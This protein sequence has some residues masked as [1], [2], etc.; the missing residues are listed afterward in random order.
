MQ[1]SQLGLSI[2]GAIGPL[3]VKSFLPDLN[4]LEQNCSSADGNFTNS[5]HYWSILEGTHNVTS[6]PCPDEM[7]VT[8]L[9]ASARFAYVTSS[10]LVVIPTA[11]FV[12]VFFL[13]A[14]SCLSPKAK[15]MDGTNQDAGEVK[16][17]Q[18]KIALL[19]GGFVLF[20]LDQP[21]EGSFSNFS[22]VFVVKG[23][24]WPNS[25]GSLIAFVYWAALSFGQLAG[26]PAAAFLS[27]ESM[28]LGLLSVTFAGAVLLIFSA[29]YDAFVWMSATIVGLG[30]GPFY[31]T[32]F[33][34]VAQYVNISGRVSAVFLAAAALGGIAN[35]FAVG[36][37]LDNCGHSSL[38]YY[39]TALTA[40]L[41][42]TYLILHIFV[43]CRNLKNENP[44]RAS[45]S[46]VRG[47]PKETEMTLLS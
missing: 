12:L 22:A 45:Q 26:I 6:A 4:F 46:D 5:T 28:M 3:T 25:H 30:I 7:E 10:V 24:G 18:L 17:R 39:V 14:P 1:M 44:D 2:G 13:D 20:F 43:R 23:L 19:V 36:Y 42:I 15:K 33:V 27:P 47:L 38:P 35:P 29:Y 16:G 40:T 21:V 31:G 11:L 8:K 9:V 41:L 37:L 32:G 34:W